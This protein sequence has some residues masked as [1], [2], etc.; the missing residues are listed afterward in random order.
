MTVTSK[1]VSRNDSGC[2]LIV[3]GQMKTLTKTILISDRAISPVGLRKVRPFSEAIQV[4]ARNAIKYFSGKLRN[5]VK[6]G[7]A[8]P[9]ISEGEGGAKVENGKY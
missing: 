8:I 2:V 6:K 5:S 3:S 9:G 1:L 4:G 7:Y